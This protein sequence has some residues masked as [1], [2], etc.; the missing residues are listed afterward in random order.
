MTALL[1]SK[2]LNVVA[3]C[4]CKYLGT[5]ANSYLSTQKSFG[6]GG[7]MSDVKSALLTPKRELSAVPINFPH[8][9]VIHTCLLQV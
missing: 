7:P 5:P 4:M 1:F 2:A 6:D 3:V 9:C 8:V